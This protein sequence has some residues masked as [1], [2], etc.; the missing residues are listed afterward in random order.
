M[1]IVYETED[2]RRYEP[3]VVRDHWGNNIQMILCEE[4]DSESGRWEPFYAESMIKMAQFD[5][6]I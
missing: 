2:F 1:K 4:L 6:R 3:E 5:E